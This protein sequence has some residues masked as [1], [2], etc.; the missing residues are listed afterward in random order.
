M[1]SAKNFRKEQNDKNEPPDQ[2]LNFIYLPA[3]MS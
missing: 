2:T 3:Y 1:Y